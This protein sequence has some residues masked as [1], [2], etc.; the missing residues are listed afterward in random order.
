MKTIIAST[1]AALLCAAP[2]RAAPQRIVSLNPCLAVI[3][4]NGAD[5]DQSAALSHLSRE[6][7]S[8]IVALANSLPSTSESAEEVMSLAP[9]LVLTSQHSSLAT[10]N[11]L[12]RLSITTA[13]FGEPQTI[14]ES[15]AQVREIAALVGHADRG[16][17][18]AARITAAVDAAAPPQGSKQITALLFQSNGFSTGHGSLLDELMTQSGFI[19]AAA[20]YGLVGWGNIGLERVVAD[21]PQILLAG[22]ARPDKPTWADRILRHPAL[23][24]LEGRMQRATFPDRLLYCAG[25]VLIEAAD[26]L[27]RAHNQALSGT[28]P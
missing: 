5:R 19:N 24:R 27:H 21:P 10:R 17:E 6:D 9:D 18:L 28:R 16:E 8:T 3:L 23:A 20:R 2:A 14:T 7:T 25:P 22:E 15:I 13:L 12:D 1:L 26:A 4:V 11:A